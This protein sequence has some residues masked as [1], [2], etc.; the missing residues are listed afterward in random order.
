MRSGLPVFATEFGGIAEIIQ[1]GENGFY[2]NPTDFDG[3]TQKI[4]DF[5]NQCNADPQVWHRISEQA[6]QHI[7]RHCNWQTHVKQLLLFARVYGF[8]DYMSRNSR[9]AL[10]CYLDALFHLLYKPR[11]AQILDEH[12]QR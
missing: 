10:Q 12:Q 8:W 7:E 11:A 3:T 2:I 5:L 1:N 6:I 9:E 4:L